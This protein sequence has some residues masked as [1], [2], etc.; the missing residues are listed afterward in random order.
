MQL[1]VLARYEQAGGKTAHAHIIVDR[2][3]M[4]APFLRDL[5]QAGQ[6]MIT[7]LRTDQYA[8]LESFTGVGTFLPLTYDR[9]GQLIREVAQ[10]CFALPLPDQVGQFLPLRVALIRDLRRQVPC[11]QHEEETEQDGRVPG[12]TMAGKLS[13]Q[14]LRR[15]WQS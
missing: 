3:G 13:R 6:T 12:G 2:E 4:A 5:A 10:A 1:N 11:S 8:G 15:Q 9:K 14:K 7:V